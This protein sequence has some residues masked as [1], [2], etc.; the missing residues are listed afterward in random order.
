MSKR[1][2]ASPALAVMLV[3]AA[4]MWY[5]TQLNKVYTD[6]E[7]PVEVSVGGET[8]QTRMLA[9]GKGFRLLAHRTFQKS[10]IALE[11]KELRVSHSPES[12]TMGVVNPESLVT[13]VARHVT[14]IKITGLND[15]IP[16]VELYHL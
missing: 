8:F 1:S 5:L 13:A 7:V 4:A 9:T 15:S 10:R 11:R 16:Q 14:D 3:V 2:I 12:D 6:V